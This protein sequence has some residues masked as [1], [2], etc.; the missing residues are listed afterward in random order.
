M[1]IPSKVYKGFGLNTLYT[2]GKREHT[3]PKNAN[4]QLGVKEYDVVNMRKNTNIGHEA[5]IS[6]ES[7][8]NRFSNVHGKHYNADDLETTTSDY[9]PEDY[10]HNDNRMFNNNIGTND[11]LGISFITLLAFSM[12]LTFVGM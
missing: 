9:G 7:F 10:Y 6:D 3:L 12:M 2:T 4:K 8:L 5:N 1:L 11:Q